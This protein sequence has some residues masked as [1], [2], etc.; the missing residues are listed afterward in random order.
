MTA[1]EVREDIQAHL[2][3]GATII[4]AMVGEISRAQALGWPLVYVP[5]F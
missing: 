1:P 2:I 5:I 3:P 4:P